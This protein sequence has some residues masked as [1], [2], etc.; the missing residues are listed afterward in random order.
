MRWWEGGRYEDAY[1][2]GLESFYGLDMSINIVCHGLELVQQFLGVIYD[3]LVFQNR[4]IVG[5]VNRRG[6]RGELSVNTLSIGV[7]LAESLKSSNGLWKK[8]EA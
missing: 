6:L 1:S 5:E 8:K 3:P 4:T 2:F 7:A